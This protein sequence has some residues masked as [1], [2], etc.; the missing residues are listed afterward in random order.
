M[1]NPA[2]PN[3]TNTRALYH[4]DGD[5]TNAARGSST[6]KILTVGGSLSTADA[7]FGA[8]SLLCY[9]RD[10]N[11]KLHPNIDWQFGTTTWTID[12][13]FK[14][15][16][17]EPFLMGWWEDNDNYL[18]IEFQR[19]AGTTGYW[20]I[21][22]RLNGL[23][24][25]TPD[26][27]P[28]SQVVMDSAWY[29]FAMTRE[30]T[31]RLSIAA[32]GDFQ[33]TGGLT[34]PATQ[35]FDLNR[36]PLYFGRSLRFG[37]DALGDFHG[38]VDEIRVHNGALVSGILGGITYHEPQ[39]KYRESVVLAG[40]GRY[41][42]ATTR[43]IEGR[44]THLLGGTQV[45]MDGP[46]VSHIYAAVQNDGPGVHQLYSAKQIDGLGE[47]SLGLASDPQMRTYRQ[48]GLGAHNIYDG[49]QIDAAGQYNMNLVARQID[50]PG[51]H[52]LRRAVVIEGR[53]QHNIRQAVQIDGS[54]LHAIRETI[55]KYHLWYNLGSAPDLTAAPDETF[56]SLPHTSAVISG[57]G[58]WYFVL[59]ELNQFG[60]YSQNITP[61]TI[62]LDGSDDQIRERPSDPD[63][64]AIF[65]IDAG[66]VRVTAQY[67]YIKDGHGL[68]GF[69]DKSA[70][71]FN[72]YTTSGGGDPDPDLDTPTTV[73]MVKKDGVA[74]LSLDVASVG[75]GVTWKAIVRTL[76][77]AGR[78]S[79]SATIKQTTSSTTGPLAPAASKAVQTVVKKGVTV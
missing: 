5:F 34:V 7:K 35:R 61:F 69:D 18:T 2:Q 15:I 42:L 20:Q 44:G 79:T 72:V 16:S 13:W 49:V 66:K 55:V 52:H 71:S 74:K 62:E 17:G 1:A 58:L 9:G 25:G 77:T 40:P 12:A 38:Y 48:N 41:N 47:S 36:W 19:L 67:D 6:E 23:D 22:H 39:E 78:E 26:G 10:N 3:D 63:A 32:D 27:G 21:R 65:A 51:T 33:A 75:D 56:A 24:I 54:G 4:F 30:S 31:T 64:F 29:H 14:F 68:S 59:R 28:Y 50:G 45:Q 60:L 46:G 53:G 43:T 73:A 70:D 76:R 8:Q 11:I 57:E 37:A